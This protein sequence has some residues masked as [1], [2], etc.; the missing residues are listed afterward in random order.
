M[1]TIKMTFSGIEI[2]SFDRKENED[3]VLVFRDNS[4][5]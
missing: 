3:N 5:L 4:W 1:R 2:V